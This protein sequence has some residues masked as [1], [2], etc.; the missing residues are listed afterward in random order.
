MCAVAAVL[1]LAD[2]LVSLARPTARRR[3]LAGLP[4]AAV[5]VVATVLAW[6]AWFDGDAD[7]VL[8]FWGALTMTVLAVLVGAARLWDRR[9]TAAR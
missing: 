5:V 7:T 9:R 2:V 6:T 8:L 4:G 1:V 3:G